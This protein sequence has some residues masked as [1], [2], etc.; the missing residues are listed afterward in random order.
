MGFSKNL[1]YLRQKKE[2]S[3]DKLADYLGYKSFTTIQKWES[4]KAE[5]NIKTLKELSLLFNVNMDDFLNKDL[6]TPSKTNNDADNFLTAKDAIISIL[7]DQSMMSYCGYDINSLSEKD[8][9]EVSEQIKEYT[10]FIT[11]KYIK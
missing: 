6:T 7:R 11:Q 5:P 1:R 10:A 8:I 4:D 3:Q 9:D 2:W